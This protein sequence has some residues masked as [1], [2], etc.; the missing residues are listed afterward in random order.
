MTIYVMNYGRSDDVNKSIKSPRRQLWTV[1]TARRSCGEP[2]L[3][4]GQI[5]NIWIY[6][7]VSSWCW[8]VL[9]SW[10]S[11]RSDAQ[12][13]LSCRRQNKDPNSLVELVCQS[14]LLVR[15]APVFCRR[16][17]PTSAGLTH[18]N[19]YLIFLSF[20]AFR[21]WNNFKQL[22]CDPIP[23]TLVIC[24]LFYTRHYVNAMFCTCKLSRRR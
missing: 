5:A 16:R 18:M 9:S 11:C 20:E 7:D 12:R 21:L 15:G 24:M 6:S 14:G 10:G 22:K 8:C 23:V 4:M 13:H 3:P 2:E 17:I 1:R 19:A